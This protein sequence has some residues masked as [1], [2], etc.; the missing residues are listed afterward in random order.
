MKITLTEIDST[1]KRSNKW[2]RY[3]DVTQIMGFALHIHD[4]GRMA[5]GVLF[6]VVH[7]ERYFEPQVP[8]IQPG[9]LRLP[10]L[11]RLQCEIV[12][13]CPEKALFGC[14]IIPQTCVLVA[15]LVRGWIRLFLTTDELWCG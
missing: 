7:G 4:Y 9:V 3:R 1:I 8:I 11:G 10:P 15:L 13:F 12:S 5:S 2:T 14:S 6:L